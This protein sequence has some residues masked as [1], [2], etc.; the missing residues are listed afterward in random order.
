MTRPHTIALWILILIGV[1]TALSQQSFVIHGKV[2]DA[3]ENEPLP[4]A[5]IRIAGS[6]LGTITNREGDFRFALRDSL[7]TLVV[8]YVGH[9]SDTVI[10]T[11]RGAHRLLIRLQP[12][13]IQ[14]AEMVVTGEDPAY[15]IIRYAIESKKKWMKRLTSYEGKAFNRLVIR[16]Q[17]SIA[18]ITESYST[19][20]WR[21]DDSLREI[22]TQQ[23]QTGNLPKSMQAVRVG[24]II[25]FNDDEITM[26]G[27]QFTGPTAPDAFDLYDYKL[28]STRRMDDFEVYEI[29]VIPKSRIN[30]LFKGMIEIAERTYAVIEADLEPNEAYGPPFIYF[31]KSHYKQ[32][33]RFFNSSV[34]LPVHYR[35]EANMELRIM[36]IKFPPI[37]VERDVVIYDYRVNPELPDSIRTISKTAVDSSAKKIDSTF[38][39][40]HDVLPLTMEQDSAYH[41][42]DSTQTLEKQFA[43]SGAMMSFMNAMTTGVLSYLDLTFNRV[44]A[45]HLGFSKT[46]DSL[47]SDL[48]VRGGVA[49]GTADERWK[50]HA[51][52]TLSFGDT[53]SRTT[54][55]GAAAITMS[56]RRWSIS[57]DMYDQLEEFPLVLMKDRFFN[58]FN[59]LFA[60]ADAYDYYRAHGVKTTVTY[61][62]ADCWR[63]SLAE[64]SENQQ[65]LAKHTEY[66]FFNRS[67]MYPDNP[68]IIDGRMNSFTLNA[69]YAT[70]EMPGITRNSFSAST[71]VEYSDPSLR[72]DYS[73]TQ[74]HL[75]LRS[76]ISTMNYNLLFPPSLTVIVNAGTTAGQ[77][78]PQRY[79]SLA[80]NVLFVG[81]QGT[82]RGVESREYYGDRYALASI[83]Y[84]FRRAPFALTG[85]KAL[86][87]SKLEFIVI[88]SVARSWLTDEALR[89]PQFPVKDT[90]GWY[91]EAGIGVS[92]IFDFFRLDLSYRFTQPGKVILTLLLSDFVS[93]FGQ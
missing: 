37:G 32:S 74:F 7:V 14:V 43:P 82:L 83:E 44:E 2:V 78:P 13:A 62:P 35:F 86:Y 1:S 46:A 84:N 16:A 64:L 29:E 10:I 60:H 93:G 5:T 36:G 61:L 69:R 65:S 81:E 66:S 87:E 40:T 76:K 70:T 47:T 56:N 38:W 17:D 58:I 92:N 72:S 33:F 75:K 73:F 49:Y 11:D 79:F 18:A 24:H 51:G 26:G 25:N 34:W 9:T 42:L 55:F 85:I 68:S 50:W 28:R 3:V 22:V 77:L 4:S 30:P 41:K 53:V 8:S 80:S 20:Y 23:K 54:A 89:T 39:A 91:Y 52:A 45:W 12:N 67:E 27:F 15:Q 48:G 71:V 31:L 57:L 6:M 88:G 63:F 19:L 59:G 90:D 21:S